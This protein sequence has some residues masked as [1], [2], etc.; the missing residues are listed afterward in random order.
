MSPLGRFL[1]IADLTSNRLLLGEKRPL[2]IHICL[3]FIKNNLARHQV[4][5]QVCKRIEY[6]AAGDLRNKFLPAIDFGSEI[7][8]LAITT[9]RIT[10]FS[11]LNSLCGPVPR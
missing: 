10:I 2:S 1:P 11:P 6:C 9:V 4:A 5:L 3:A 7:E 8:Y